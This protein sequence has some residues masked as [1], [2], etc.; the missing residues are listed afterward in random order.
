MENL[1]SLTTKFLSDLKALPEERMGLE[2][3]GRRLSTLEASDIA[4]FFDTVYKRTRHDKA[5]GKVLSLL[6]DPAGLKRILGP[7]KWD[8]VYMASIEMGLDKVS[9]LFT[10]LPPHKT[11]VHG[12]DK[13]E[14]A[15]M[16][17]LTLGERRSISKSNVKD[18]IDRLLS[19]PDPVVITNILNNPRVTE[20]EVLK[21][22]SKRP[23]SPGILKLV[24]THRVWSKRYAVKKAVASNP[25]CSPRVSIALL[26]LLLTQDLKTIAGDNSVHPQVKLSAEEIVKHRG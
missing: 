24:A 5:A 3:L 14:E 23:N 19:D 20:R 17:L 18:N 21:V 10:D 13:E 6:I 26:E 16:E 12:Y 25:Y 2:L 7:E 1:D 8:M 4:G 15:R 9:R 11:G 22:A